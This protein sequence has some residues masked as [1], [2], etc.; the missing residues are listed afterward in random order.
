VRDK[1]TG[2]G[3]PGVTLRLVQLPT[4]GAITRP[5]GEFSII[6]VPA[7]EYTIRA[8][9][10]GYEQSE[11][12]NVRVSADAIV[13]VNFDME[14]K[15][16]Q[17]KDTIIVVAQRNPMVDPS[18]MTTKRQFTDEEI[19]QIPRETVQG[20]LQ[21]TAGVTVDNTNGGYSIRG[22]R[23]TETSVRV[24]NMEIG[25]R[26]NGALGTNAT[27]YPTVPILGVQEVQVV[28]GGFAA[29][30][31][32]ALSGI[33]NTVTKEG[34][35]DKYEGEIDYMTDAGGGLNGWNNNGGFTPMK[36][37]PLGEN[38]IN[39]GV[40]GPVP[41]IAGLRF[42]LSGLTNAVQHRGE[43]ASYFALPARLE[44]IDPSGGNVGLLANDALYQRTLSAKLN[45]DVNPDTKLTLEAINGAT[46]YGTGRWAWMYADASL[47]QPAAGQSVALP[48]NVTQDGNSMTLTSQYNFELSQTVGRSTVY[49]LGVGF[50]R[51][52]T[53]FG[54]KNAYQ[55][56]S[57]LSWNGW[58]IYGL[59]DNYTGDQTS[60]TLKNGQINGPDGIADVY[61]NP[62]SGG[63]LA[64]NAITGHYEGYIDVSSTH[65]PYGVQGVFYTTG[66]EPYQ[67][68]SN[69][70]YQVYGNI[71]S[72]VDEHN[73]VKGGF[74]GQ[75]YH[76]TKNDNFTPWDPAAAASGQTDSYD[77][78]P[79]NGDAY[80]Q[81][82]VEFAGILLNPGLRLDYFN[83]RANFLKDPNNY[84]PYY[85]GSPYWQ[86][87]T[88]KTQLSPRFGIS[89]PISDRTQFHISYGWFFQ[90]PVYDQLFS[91]LQSNV[92]AAT[93]VTVGS[94]NLTPQL[95]K[96]YEIGFT[97]QLSEDFSLDLVA[98]YNDQYN[99]S[100]TTQYSA[101]TSQGSN[102]LAYTLY[103][104]GEYANQR[105]VE[106]TLRKNLSSNYSLTGSL[107]LSESR[108]TSS[109]VT[110]SQALSQKTAADP[111]N[112]NQSTTYYPTTDFPL[113]LD[114]PVVAN[115]IFNIIYGKG[116]GPSFGGVHI[117]ENLNINVT[118]QYHSGTPYTRLDPK[119][120]A[121]V[122]DV[123]GSRE[124]DFFQAD[125]RIERFI[126]L[127]DI[128][129]DWAGNMQMSLF[130]QINNF[131]N[132]TNPEFVYATSGAA[133]YDNKTLKLGDFDPTIW[134]KGGT[135]PGQT[136][137]YGRPLY[138]TAADVNGDGV[139]DQQEKYNAYLKYV[140]DAFARR[141]NYQLPR[142]VFF[143]VTLQF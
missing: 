87:S 50:Y 25:D 81:D 62:S 12:T 68:E 128:F 115:L 104:T 88:P 40:G 14:T 98:Y 42:Y 72:Q 67:F 108:G 92:S 48:E 136:D 1:K 44:L 43:Y 111:Y 17:G 8:S 3:L 86:A 52:E 4:R 114:Q 49:K 45:Y 70:Y 126:P 91:H 61:Y 107:T 31:G 119:T 75:F 13:Q 123:N 112:N 69:Q 127:K 47:A 29:E 37:A 24:D 58:D 118:A 28:S 95:S 131:L 113:D 7:G 41:S 125:G 74:E 130:I 56:Y 116:E 103:S 21:L 65:N 18:R 139:V 90:E 132:T 55:S 142:E 80:I 138:S 15:V 2:E 36:L 133:N 30:Y 77:Y 76:V 96:K 89:Y 137:T 66:D 122:G 16:L 64:R 35:A 33:V 121:I 83:P 79:F 110:Q 23:S 71:Q 10:V 39:F 82:Q 99:I 46:F 94:P 54:K 73:L 5:T 51:D 38:Q 6:N 141:A 34:R 9:A 143:G 100:G 124:P 101:I 85:P 20:V 32:D 106:I 134:Y 120:G 129:G 109:S 63:T 60:A 27:F 57:P 26:Q 105:G 97:H 19:R 53:T 117:L 140:N 135:G 102:S 78:S 11:K 22:G 59:Q 84:Q 93:T